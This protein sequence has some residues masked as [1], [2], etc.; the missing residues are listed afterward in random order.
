M[1]SSIVFRY[2]LIFF[3]FNSVFKLISQVSCHD[4][5]ANKKKQPQPDYKQPQPDY[6]GKRSE[7][8]E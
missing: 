7:I 1:A 3:K 2:C 4:L 6:K 8:R 5:P